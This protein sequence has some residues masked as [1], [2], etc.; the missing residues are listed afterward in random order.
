MREQIENGDLV[1]CR[2]RLGHVVLDWIIEFQLA[3]F[4]E[5][6]NRRSGELLGDRSESKLRRRGVGNVP[7]EVCRPIAFAEHDIAAAGD[8][9]R[10]HERLVADVTLDDVVHALK[11]LCQARGRDKKEDDCA[12][13]GSHAEELIA[14]LTSPCLT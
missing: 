1:P 6:E 5:Q 14:E 7:L 2:R 11:V 3:A 12:S 13:N 10:A 8:E 4:L 9:H